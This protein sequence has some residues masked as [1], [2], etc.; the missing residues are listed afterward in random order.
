[1]FKLPELTYDYNE[2]EPFISQ[3]TMWLHHTKHHQAYVDGA[4]KALYNLKCQYY[5]D[6]TGAKLE[7]INND[8]M[9]NVAGH[10]NHCL[11]WKML[12]P[13]SWEKYLPDPNSSLFKE[14]KAT[15]GSFSD[16]KKLFIDFNSNLRG[17]GWIGLGYNIHIQQLVLYSFEGQDGKK[18]NG[19]MPVLLIDLWEHSYYL[20]YKSDRK[21]YLVECLEI[22]NWEYCNSL[23]T[24]YT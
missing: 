22:I 3:E 8:L 13:R 24:S 15:F 1:M 14:I 9:F 5:Y 18:L 17:P 10:R 4:N 6:N 20:D 11:F 19:T 12:A 21:R 7:K 2:L 23:F 16:F